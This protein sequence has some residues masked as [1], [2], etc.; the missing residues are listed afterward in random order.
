MIFDVAYLFKVDILVAIINNIKCAEIQ[1]F[2]EIIIYLTSLIKDRIAVSLHIS[3]FAKDL[4]YLRRSLGGGRVC[5]P[6]VSECL[7]CTDICI[8]KSVSFPHPSVH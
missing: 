7:G 4:P 6:V 5:I 8:P 1:G 2:I 3:V